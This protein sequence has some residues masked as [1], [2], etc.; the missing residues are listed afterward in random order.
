MYEILNDNKK[1]EDMIHVIRGVQVLL[2]SDLVIFY[3]CING[4]KIINQ[5]VKKHRDRFSSDFMF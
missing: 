1:I 4:T 2:D 5:T 3:H